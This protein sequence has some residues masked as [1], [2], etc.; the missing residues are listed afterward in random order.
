M[1]KR[2]FDEADNE[3]SQSEPTS[4]WG[5]SSENN[6]LEESKSLKI[7]FK[8]NPK[9]ALIAVAGI[10]GLGIIA[11]V[12]GGGSNSE[13]VEVAA[14]DVTQTAKPVTPANVDLYAQ[15]TSL[16]SFI[17]TAQ[18]ST[19][20]IICG[21]GFGTGWAIDLSDDPSTSRDDAY[22]TEIITN[23]HVIE[24]C[25]VGGTVEIYTFGK[26]VPI[27]ALVYSA[28][29]VNDLAIVI[30]GEYLPPMATL[31][32][33]DESKVGQWVMAFG[34][35]GG[36]N[37]EILEG[38]VTSGNIT[39]IINTSIVTDTVINPGNSGGPLVNSAGEVIAINTEKKIDAR[40]NNIGYARK[41]G[42]ICVQLQNCT[43][44]II[45]K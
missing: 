41:V 23:N 24:E 30:T 33:S 3:W 43:K 18:A 5:D 19:V 35:P 9:I 20:T 10:A 22:S 27:Y 2:M 7:R 17:D 13:K 38:S 6:D 40:V 26:R 34:S 36:I 32:Q 39:N 45:N 31:S 12:L 4:I 42:L 1:S 8:I 21:N 44:K 29:T 16:Q 37:G 25:G 14:P 15:P 11:S 28:D